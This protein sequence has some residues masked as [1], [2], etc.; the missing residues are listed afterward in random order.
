MAGAVLG[1]TSLHCC[2][3]TLVGDGVTLSVP[4]CT[5]E[6]AGPRSLKSRDFASLPA[7]II[8]GILRRTSDRNSGQS[9]VSLRYMSCKHLQRAGQDTDARSFPFNRIDTVA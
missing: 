4:R 2:P 3:L 6:S 7:L 1:R 8:S 5:T 9:A